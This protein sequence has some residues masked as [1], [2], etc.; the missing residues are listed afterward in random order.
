[1]RTLKLPQPDPMQPQTHAA[2]E[3]GV[4]K[5]RFNGGKEVKSLRHPGLASFA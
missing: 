2:K 5:L 4:M 1:M 3:D